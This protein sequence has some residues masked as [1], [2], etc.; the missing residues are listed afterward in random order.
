MVVEVQKGGEVYHCSPIKH[1]GS[2]EILA[3]KGRPL[4]YLLALFR[5]PSFCSDLSSHVQISSRL[6]AVGGREIN[7]RGYKV[8]ELEQILKYRL[9]APTADALSD[10][11]AN[12]DDYS[13][14]FD[15]SVLRFIA[16]ASVQASD[17]RRAVQVARKTLLN[18]E[19]QFLDRN[20]N[21]YGL[22]IP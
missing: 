9:G 7:F 13:F 16:T 20:Q 14:L 5:H 19:L 3:T 6:A 10:E 17:T 22:Y 4:P 11:K 1:S 2:V 21:V 8:D 15:E 18:A 12:G